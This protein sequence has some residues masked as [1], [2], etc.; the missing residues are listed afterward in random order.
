MKTVWKRIAKIVLVIM[1]L[2]LV[3]VGVFAFYYSRPGQTLLLTVNR[4][5]WERQKITHY[6]FALDIQC[7]C[8][9]RDLMPLTIEVK[10]G[11]IISVVDVNGATYD[12]NVYGT[13]D[14]PRTIE[15][16]FDAVQMGLS[17]PYQVAARYNG[18]YGFPSTINIL[19]NFE[20]K[21]AVDADFS[22]VISNFEV[23]R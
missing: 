16:L 15:M 3:L 2:C 19:I 8:E 7:F 18:K 14:D 22:Y 23:L 20:G 10:N 9:F 21:L 1:G 11:D 4:A 17:D 6:R 13:I 12:E 5:K